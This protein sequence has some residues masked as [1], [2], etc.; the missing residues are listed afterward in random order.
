MTVDMSK[1]EELIELKLMSWLKVK[2]DSQILQPADMLFQRLLVGSKRVAM[3]SIVHSLS[4]MFG[5]SI[6]EQIAKQISLDSGKYQVVESQ[7]NIG[8]ELYTSAQI[9][10]TAICNQISTGE[11]EA[12]HREEVRRIL[13]ASLADSDISKKDVLKV[14][15]LLINS[16][17]RIVHLFDLK[18]AK[19]NKHNFSSFKQMLL[20]WV[21]AYICENRS[22]N[23]WVTSDWDIKASVA[24]PYNPNYPDDYNWWT[25]R[26]LDENQ[27]MVGSDF[28]NYI[29]DDESAFSELVGC[30][31]RVSERLSPMLESYLASVEEQYDEF[32]DIYPVQDIFLA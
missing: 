14:D 7:Y 28:W 13:N 19:P 15:L 4:T 11:I 5:M 9:E 27:I 16:D 29:A 2:E 17:D 31:K 8:N 18:T 21:A 12:N 26:M 32:D 20:E 24:I 30:F 10:I 6:Y 23:D 3:S 25:F 1:V 22:T